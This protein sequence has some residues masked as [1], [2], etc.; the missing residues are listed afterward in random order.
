MKNL[1]LLLAV[2]GFLILTACRTHPW[3]IKNQ[4]PKG[5][6]QSNISGIVPVDTKKRT[7]VIRDL[8]NKIISI[9]AI[10]GDYVLVNRISNNFAIN[11]KKP[12]GLFIYKPT[13]PILLPSDVKTYI[14]WF[15]E[16]SE[17]HAMEMSFNIQV[18][19]RI[20]N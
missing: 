6:V 11:I 9:N 12:V 2:A 19:T 14:V 20:L 15:D 18:E 5:L 16:N 8:N 17:V 7:M 4:R 1:V 10:V 3:L 13:M